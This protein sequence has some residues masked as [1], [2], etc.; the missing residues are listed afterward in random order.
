[1]SNKIEINDKIEISRFELYSLVLPALNLCTA[2]NLRVQD[3]ACG[4][5]LEAV[6]AYKDLNKLLDMCKG[7]N[8]V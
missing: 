5:E 4:Y 1:M 6:R 7:V 2:I 8:N 3:H